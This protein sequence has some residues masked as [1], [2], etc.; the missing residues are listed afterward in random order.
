MQVKNK[1]RCKK[2]SKELE[3]KVSKKSSKE[4]GIKV[5]QKKAMKKAIECATGMQLC[6]KCYKVCKYARNVAKKWS[7]GM[8][9][10]QQGSR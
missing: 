5:C 2:S 7:I 9:E 10:K 6:K 1:K 3:N 4:L 8:Q